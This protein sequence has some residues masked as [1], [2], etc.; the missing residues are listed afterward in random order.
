MSKTL[1]Y[2]TCQIDD[3][4]FFI[5]PGSRFTR[6]ELKSRL[7]QMNL[8]C[9]EVQDKKQLVTLYDSALNGHRQNK[10]S[11]INS[12]RSDT[13]M[14]KKKLGQ[15]PKKT[16][17]TQ[18][19]Q[20][21][22]NNQKI[23]N[24]SDNNNFMEPNRLRGPKKNNNNNKNYQMNNNQRQ[25]YDYH[26]NQNLQ[27][28]DYENQNSGN[29]QNYNNRR[30]HR[31]K[32]NN[33]TY[34]EQIQEKMEEE[35]GNNEPLFRKGEEE[36]SYDEVSTFSFFS[37]YQNSPL[38]KNR[39]A[40]LL[41]T[42]ISFIVIILAYYIG[43]DNISTFFSNLLTQISNPRAIL[44]SIADFISNLFSIA[45]NRFYI[46]IPVILLIIFVIY[47]I[48]RYRFKKLCKEIFGKMEKYLTQDG[49]RFIYEKDIYIKYCK[50]YGITED[51]FQKEYL[52]ELEKMRRKSSLKKTSDIVEGKSYN[53]WYC[54][55]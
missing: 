16:P 25:Y 1:F 17:D 24:Y 46:T 31:M 33:N 48:K 45:I 10:I 9:N 35:D 38:Y 23:V 49:N 39:R 26:N 21:N 40:I 4:I 42:L 6:N 3:E 54:Q 22:Q 29:F 36:K 53:Y 52:P 11:I 8:D 18:I 30:E 2:P 7:H 14:I 28:S 51:E 20:L 55:M 32:P 50:D 47:I 12:L 37:N 5:L 27:R 15:S 34:D 43:F 19:I 41:T 13:E 44:N